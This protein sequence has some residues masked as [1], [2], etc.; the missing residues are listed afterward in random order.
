[1][2]KMICRPSCEGYVSLFLQDEYFEKV[3][4]DFHVSKAAVVFAMC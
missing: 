3:H 2:K 4:A 1:M